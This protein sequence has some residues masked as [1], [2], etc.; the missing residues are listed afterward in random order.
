M[1]FA[2]TSSSPKNSKSPAAVGAESE[3]SKVIVEGSRA[4]DAEP[5]HDGEAGSIDNGKVLVA[6]G[7]PNQP[8][9]FQIRH[10]DWFDSGR[11]V[12]QT[13]PEPL[14]SLAPDP[15][16]QQSPGFE[17]ASKRYGREGS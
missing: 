16:P 6:I 13:F 17:Q 14:G 10:A 3:Y 2:T 7:D 1:G 5:A 15:V 4:L 11:S 8:G 12:A 9:S